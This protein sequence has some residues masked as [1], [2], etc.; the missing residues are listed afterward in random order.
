MKQEDIIRRLSKVPIFK[1]LSAKELDPIV[2]IAQT[3]FY[4]H[5]MYV[6]MQDDPLDRVFLFIQEK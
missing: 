4:K 3:R 1:E 6:F 5:K 2:K